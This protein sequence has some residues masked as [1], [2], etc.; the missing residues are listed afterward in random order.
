MTEPSICVLVPD[1]GDDYR[2]LIRRESVG[3]EHDVYEALHGAPIGTRI[4][5]GGWCY[6]RAGDRDR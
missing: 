4:V 6:E 5:I 2:R 3:Y 1:A